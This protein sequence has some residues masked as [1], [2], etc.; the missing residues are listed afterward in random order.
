MSSYLLWKSQ[1]PLFWGITPV[2]GNYPCFGEL[3]LFWELPAKEDADDEANHDRNCNEHKRHRP[4]DLRGFCTKYIIF[5]KTCIIVAYKMH[6][7]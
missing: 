1:E 2:L 7:H 6:P 4:Q 3:P 5:S